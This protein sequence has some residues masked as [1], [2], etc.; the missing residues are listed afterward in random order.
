MGIASRESSHKLSGSA[1]ELQS[2][3]SASSSETVGGALF[4]LVK[5][6][7]LWYTLNIASDNTMNIHEKLL[8]ASEQLSDEQLSILLNV[9][10]SLKSGKNSVQQMVLSQ[11]YQDWLSAENDIYDE[12]FADELSL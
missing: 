12:L 10:L 5:F 3:Y 4:P 11:G 2:S 9:A 8:S 6:S 7:I 1:D